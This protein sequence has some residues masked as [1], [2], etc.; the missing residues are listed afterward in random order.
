[1]IEL[2]NAIK[3]V[4]NCK[5]IKNGMKHGLEKTMENQIVKKVAIR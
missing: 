5:M 2:K 1:M 4:K 3:N